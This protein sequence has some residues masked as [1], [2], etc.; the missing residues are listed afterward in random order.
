[1]GKPIDL[2]TPDSWPAPVRAALDAHRTALEAWELDLPGK[3]ARTFDLAIR[4]V[5]DAL[6]P[7]SLRGWHCTRLTT[8]EAADIQLG[9][10]EVLDPGL[11][12]RRIGAQESR[13]ALTSQQAQ[14]LRTR[15]QARESGRRG[16]CW[17]CFYPPRLAGQHGM[18]RLFTSWGG[19]A[20]YNY[21]EDDP[22]VGPALREIGVPTLVEAIVPITHLSSPDRVAM[23]VARLDVHNRRTIIKEVTRLEDYSVTHVGAQHIERLIHFPEAEFVGLTASEHWNPPLYIGKYP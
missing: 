22:D 14:R 3:S 21:Y 13:G 12:E 15:N 19:E 9:G 4:A 1:M 2:Q 18:E 17:F 7:F 10:L 11:L 20:L 23:T 16:K 8:G 6:T 5:G